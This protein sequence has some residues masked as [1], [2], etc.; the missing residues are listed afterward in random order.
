VKRFKNKNKNKNIV[1]ICQNQSNF[2]QR[3][4]NELP[5]ILHPDYNTA[6][7]NV[8]FAEKLT[9]QIQH[10]SPAN[11]SCLGHPDTPFFPKNFAKYCIS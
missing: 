2:S 6:H 9:S 3:S 4:Q 1:I 8:S 7:L 10:F 11:L 5:S